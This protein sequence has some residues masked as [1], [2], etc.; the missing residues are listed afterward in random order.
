MTI[1]E[2]S[3]QTLW[4]PCSQMKDYE[5][6]KPLV[7]GKAQGSYLE[8]VSGEKIIDAI[9]SWWC[10]S[11]GHNHPHLKQ[12]LLAQVEKFE[13]V[14]LANTTNE[15]IVRLSE[16]LTQLTQTLNKV[17]YAGDGSCAVEIALK[18]CLHARQILGEP[19]RHRFIALD[20]GYHGETMGALSVS[21]VGLYRHRTDL[22]YFPSI[23]LPPGMS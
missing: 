7:I 20:N 16:K 12:A 14:I 15:T 8:L 23:S 21:D 1:I 6:F 19:Q 22:C 13:H 5:Q 3:L 4:N 10:K 11:L 2:K 18:M 9:S 17:F